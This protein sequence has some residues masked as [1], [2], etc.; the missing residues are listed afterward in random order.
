LTLKRSRTGIGRSL[1]NVGNKPV[2]NQVWG[3]PR[4]TLWDD[5]SAVGDAMTA[6][7]TESRVFALIEEHQAQIRAL[8]VKRLGL[9]GSFLR[10]EQDEDSDVDLL[11]EFDPG[12]KTFDGFI[13]LVFLLEE[14]LGRRVELVTPESL[15]PYIGPR[16]LN[17][18]KYVT[19]GA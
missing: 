5:F 10:G 17:E 7:A 3:S 6:V 14:L 2:P 15:S 8:G 4:E 18:V 16:I 12:K 19:F 13:G 9:F 1:P 11:V